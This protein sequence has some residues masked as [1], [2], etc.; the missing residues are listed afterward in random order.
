MKYPKNFEFQ[1][2]QSSRS[3]DESSVPPPKSSIEKPYNIFRSNQNPKIYKTLKYPKNFKFQNFQS[4]RS[5][6]ESSVSPPKSSIENLYDFFRSTHNPK[7]YTTL[8][9]AFYGYFTALWNTEN[10]FPKTNP[11]TRNQPHL[12]KNF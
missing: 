4:S 2:F 5:F 11:D 3:S 9:Y 8:K 12:I 1:N 6:D 7:I 10:K